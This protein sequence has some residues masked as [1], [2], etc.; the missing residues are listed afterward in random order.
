MSGL[1]SVAKMPPP[2]TVDPNGCENPKPDQHPEVTSKVKSE[3]YDV[4]C[5]L[6]DERPSDR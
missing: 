2:G 3:K 5:H 1:K 6:E 4:E